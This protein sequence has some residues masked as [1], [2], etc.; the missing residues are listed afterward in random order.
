MGANLMSR[1]ELLGA[2]L[3]PVGSRTRTKDA[4]V[5][6]CGNGSRRWLTFYVIGSVTGPHPI[7]KFAAFRA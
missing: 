5:K 3:R 2:R 6:R 4:L 1:M 7:Q